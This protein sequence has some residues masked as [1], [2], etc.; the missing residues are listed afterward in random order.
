MGFWGLSQ[1]TISAFPRPYLPF[2]G[3]LCDAA[4]GVLGFLPSVRYSVR[5]ARPQ[6]VTRFPCGFFHGIS[7]RS[8]CV[9]C[10]VLSST[11]RANFVSHFLGWAA[12]PKVSSLHRRG[13]G[14]EESG[15]RGSCSPKFPTMSGPRVGS[16]ARFNLKEAPIRVPGWWQWAVTR[17]LSQLRCS[18]T[19]ASGKFPRSSF[20]DTGNIVQE[21]RDETFLDATTHTLLHAIPRP[22]LGPFPSIGG[23]AHQLLT[24]L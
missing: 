24:T 15:R 12:R 4:R 11:G 18:D 14:S 20:R 8:V 19:F 7:S 5:L 17:G 2:L 6:M 13:P 9:Y 3:F 22:T 10:H 1:H 16:K 23:G 21:R